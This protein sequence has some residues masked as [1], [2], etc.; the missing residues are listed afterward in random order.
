MAPPLLFH[1]ALKSIPIRAALTQI[2]FHA[3]LS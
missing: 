1:G 2:L 3:A